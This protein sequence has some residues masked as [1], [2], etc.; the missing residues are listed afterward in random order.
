MPHLTDL[1]HPMK[2]NS[3]KFQPNY[4][5][6]THT[7]FR[8]SLVAYAKLIDSWVSDLN[9]FFTTQRYCDRP[10]CTTHSSVFWCMGAL[11]FLFIDLNC[12]RLVTSL[13]SYSNERILQG[14]Q[15]KYCSETGPSWSV[16]KRYHV[17]LTQLC[18]YHSPNLVPRVFPLLGQEEERPETRLSFT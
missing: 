13:G 4:E 18:R 2:L 8:S 11:Q 3:V 15:D 14:L 10:W 1:R 16:L 7:T 5:R 12:F 9:Q 17:S 6:F